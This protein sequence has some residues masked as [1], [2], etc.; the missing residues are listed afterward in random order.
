MGMSGV[1]MPGRA[2]E[3]GGGDGFVEAFVDRGEYPLDH[4]DANDPALPEERQS[5]R[6]YQE[7]EDENFFEDV[8]NIVSDLADYSS[9]QHT[10]WASCISRIEAV[11]NVTT[12][13]STG[14]SPHELHFGKRAIDQIDELITFPPGIELT[15]CEKNAIAESRMRIFFEYRKRSQKSVSKVSLEIGDLVLLRVP[16]Q[17]RASD[18]VTSKFFHLYQGPYRIGKVVGNN[19]FLL[20]DPSDPTIVKNVYNRCS[21]RR[22]NSPV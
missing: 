22:Y 18:R 15:H 5:C 1:V 20:V 7:G 14:F 19:A 4:D 16:F 9:E 8:N 12:H 11:L 17:S 10:K 13:S 21:L 6:L 2:V 3:H